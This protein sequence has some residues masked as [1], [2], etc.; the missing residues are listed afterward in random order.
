[1]WWRF[2]KIFRSIFEKKESRQPEKDSNIITNPSQFRKSLSF[3]DLIKELNTI[4][5]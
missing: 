2:R 4:K 1:M 3:D 5:T